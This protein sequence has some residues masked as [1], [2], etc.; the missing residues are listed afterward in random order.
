MSKY[1]NAQILEVFLAVYYNPNITLTD[2]ALAH[3]FSKDILSK[4]CSGKI[5]TWLKLEYTKEYSEVL[6]RKG[7][8]K[9]GPKLGSIR[10]PPKEDKILPKVISPLGV[11]YPVYCQIAFGLEHKIPRTSLCRLI[12]KQINSSLGW[13]LYKENSDLTKDTN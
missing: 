13:K 2:I 4:I 3:D 12:N 7:L 5:H 6:S 8:R 9:T 1:S 11:V 10:V